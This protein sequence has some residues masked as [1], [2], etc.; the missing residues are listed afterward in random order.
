MQQIDVT[1]IKISLYGAILPI[2]EHTN[3]D[4]YI[5]EIA[6]IVYIIIHICLYN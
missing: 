2:R 1:G 6:H 4:A 5:P 3:D